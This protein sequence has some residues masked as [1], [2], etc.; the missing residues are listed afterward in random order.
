LPYPIAHR[1][2]VGWV[3]LVIQ[4]LWSVL[5]LTSYAQTPEGRRV[6]ASRYT[7]IDR[8][9]RSEFDK[10]SRGGL[11]VGVLEGGRLAWRG[12]YGSA[13][14]E[15]RLRTNDQTIYPIASLTKMVT[16]FM[17]LQLVER[18][19]VHLADPVNVHVPEVKQIPNP[20]P[21]APPITLIQ[22]ATMTSGL[23]GELREP[24]GCRNRSLGKTSPCSALP[25]EV[26]LR[27]RDEA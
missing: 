14:E 11:S 4:L 23:E 22:L 6:Q 18:G 10:D 16:G 3:A 24:C 13:N 12:N 7:Q 8:L 25:L 1:A 2:V 15:G 17:L 20:F 9:I 21:C 5:L 19:K 27:T 26:R